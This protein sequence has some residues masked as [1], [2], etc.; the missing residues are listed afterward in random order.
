MRGEHFRL[1][2]MTRTS[3]LAHALLLGYGQLLIVTLAALVLTPF[4][5]NRLGAQDYGLWLVVGQVLGLLGL[6]DLGVTA[7]LSREVAAASGGAKPTAAVA[8]VARRATW[9]VW[10]Q[11]PVVAIVAVL[12]WTLLAVRRPEL[13]APFG[14]ILGAFVVLFP[15]RVFA[16]ILMGLQDMAVST[17]AQSAGWAVTTALTVGLVLAGC[18]LYALVVAWAVGQAVAAIV[19][20]LRIRSRFPWVWAWAGRPSWKSLREYLSQ[21]GWA[22]VSQLAHL[23]VSAT[24][25]VILGAL[26]GAP[27][28]VVYAC[29]I[30]LVTV[31]NNYPYLFASSALPAVAELQAG[32]DRD[33]LLRACQAVGLGV[34]GLSGAMAV[35]IV[36]A[37][38]AFVSLWVGPDQ[39]GGPTLTLI[40]VLA[41]VT[42]HWAYALVQMVFAL[43][44]NQRLAWAGAGDGVVT[45]VATTVWGAGLGILGGPLGS[46]TGVLLISGPIIVATLSAA[47]GVSPWGLVRWFA[48]WAVRFA[49]VFVP[50]AVASYF[51]GATDPVIA[52]GVTG[53]VL[54]AYAVVTRPLLTREPLAGYWSQTAASVRQGFGALRL[55]AR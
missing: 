6:L 8:E 38:P 1:S 17:A 52:L 32:V 13:A 5:L 19:C 9:L 50:V 2:R 23:L 37:T 51:P 29:T 54:L 16:S 36:A 24:D 35:A 20:F 3:R 14:L 44:C 33:R 45:V 7:I 41:M 11:T 26:L 48:P 18:G 30:K 10:L 43:G 39:Y 31:L 15:M 28:V 53:M 46:L 22:S 34:M 47:T 25:L 55:R 21:S 27:A 4:L 42:R 12:V 49:V 40:A